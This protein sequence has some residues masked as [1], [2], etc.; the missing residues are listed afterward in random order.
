MATASSAYAVFCEFLSSSRTG[1]PAGIHQAIRIISR[2]ASEQF[3]K[4]EAMKEEGK[5]NGVLP[6]RH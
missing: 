4:L 5:G 6:L 3:A 1:I 2:L